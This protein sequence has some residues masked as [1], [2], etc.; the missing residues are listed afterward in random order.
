MTAADYA[1]SCACAAAIFKNSSAAAWRVQRHRRSDP[2][3]SATMGM[4]P[5]SS[6]G[7]VFRE[8]NA[9]KASGL[10]RDYAIGGATSVLFYAEPARTYDVDVFILLAPA[11]PAR[12]VSLERIYEWAKKSN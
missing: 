7:D 12:L 4:R 9:L 6:L 5:M 11:S 3:V 1:G 10:V 2:F 8:L